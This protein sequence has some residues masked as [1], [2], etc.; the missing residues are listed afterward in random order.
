MKYTLIYLQCYTT[1]VNN[2]FSVSRQQLITKNRDA[3]RAFTNKWSHMSKNKNIWSG[4]KMNQ[5]ISS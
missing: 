2:D 3:K 5:L 4:L 1:S